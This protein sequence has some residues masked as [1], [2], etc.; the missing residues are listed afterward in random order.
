[1]EDIAKFKSHASF[2]KFSF[3][4]ITFLEFNHVL[5]VP[6]VD[7]DYSEPNGRAGVAF[8]VILVLLAVIIA[9]LV[10]AVVR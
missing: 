5:V 9:V 6:I 1:M 3:A 2:L 8:G 4:Q 7:G 10:V